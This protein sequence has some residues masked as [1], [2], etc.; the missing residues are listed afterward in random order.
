M[1]NTMT[2]MVDKAL[3]PMKP[4]RRYFRHLGLGLFS[5]V[6]AAFSLAMEVLDFSGTKQR[7]FARNGNMVYQQ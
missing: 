1:T 2:T 7:I 5:V 6:F 4:Q 3:K